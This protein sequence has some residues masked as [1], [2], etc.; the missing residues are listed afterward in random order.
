MLKELE[1]KSGDLVKIALRKKVY[2]FSKDSGSSKLYSL[3]DLKEKLSL[4]SDR[5]K[6]VI[7]KIAANG[8]VSIGTLQG[9]CDGVDLSEGVVYIKPKNLLSGKK[10]TRLMISQE[11]INDLEIIKN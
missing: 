1:I 4:N 10:F 8:F 2:Y 11:Q 5:K 7:R 3:D 9:C 6:E